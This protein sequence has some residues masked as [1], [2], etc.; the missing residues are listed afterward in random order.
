MAGECRNTTEV[1][2]KESL[3][4]AV[5][6]N[7]ANSMKATQKRPEGPADGESRDNPE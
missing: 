7:S 3:I 6:G 5:F 1:S 2:L 4:R